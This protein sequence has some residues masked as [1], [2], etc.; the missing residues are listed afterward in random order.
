L[1]ID[2]KKFE[3]EIND[4]MVKILKYYDKNAMGEKI[5]KKKLMK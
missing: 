4:L 1:E 2:L 5:E 3:S